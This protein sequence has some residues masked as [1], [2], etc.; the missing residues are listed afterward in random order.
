MP[1]G[2]SLAYVSGDTHIPVPIARDLT[3]RH[4][5]KP[6]PPKPTGLDWSALTR[7]C[8]DCGERSTELR[9]GICPTCAAPAAPVPPAA[10]TT[11]GKRARAAGAPT[12]LP[13]VPKQRPPM[14]SRT[15]ANMP[16]I[17]RLYLEE[18]LSIPEIGRRL[19]HSKHSVR[20]WL[21]RDG[22]ELRDDRGQ[23]AATLDGH[24]ADELRRLYTDEHLTIAQISER[25]G[26]AYRTTQRLMHEA[27]IDVRVGR[28]AQSPAQRAINGAPTL[29]QRITA[30]GVTSAQVKAWALAEGL[31]YEVQVGLPPNR[32]V[33]A[34]EN[35]HP[36]PEQESA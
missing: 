6:Q 8:S 17:R 5:H 15:V 25:I 7:T 10:S 19:G 1:T 20:A 34:F 28:P 31:I 35:A 24:L 21:T 2:D 12:R 29:K 14:N 18:R 32:I 26:R 4:A 13:K 3:Y 33:T 11:K 22:V 30:L 16:E 27:G 36:K 23:H 9:D